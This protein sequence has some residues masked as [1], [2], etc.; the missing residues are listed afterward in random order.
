MVVA[1]LVA[2]GPKRLP[3][4]VVFFLVAVF[5]LVVFLAVFLAIFLV[6]FFAVFFAVFFLMAFFLGLSFVKK[7]KVTLTVER[8]H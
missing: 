7:S 1:F 4:V 5:F 3:N 8:P 6:V 2:G